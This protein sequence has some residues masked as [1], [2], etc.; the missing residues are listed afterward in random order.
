MIFQIP[1]ENNTN[2]DYNNYVLSE[3]QGANIEIQGLVGTN[4]QTV[5]IFG[6][7]LVDNHLVTLIAEK[8]PL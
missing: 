3:I 1:I 4:A 8:V 6:K 5:Y 7:D 2:N